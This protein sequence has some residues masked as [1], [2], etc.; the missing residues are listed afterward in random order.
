MRGLGHALDD[1]R[2]RRR[3]L[4]REAI[5]V[6]EILQRLLELRL[7][8]VVN[9]HERLALFH[10]G[11]DLLDLRDADR[12]VDLVV[13]LLPAGAEEMHAAGDHG[14]VDR[15]HVA[16]LRARAACG[17]ASPAGIS[18]GGRCRWCR[19]PGPGQAP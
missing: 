16:A 11:A 15:V 17:C 13:R 1:Q 2:R 19:R 18:P 4:G 10:L 6:L 12:V 7:V 9:H 14:R 5:G 3:A 8:V